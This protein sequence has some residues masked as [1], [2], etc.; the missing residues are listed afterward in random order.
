VKV[1]KGLG[2]MT[3]AIHCAGKRVATGITGQFK[4]EQLFTSECL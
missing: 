4:G 1:Y 2:T 3:T